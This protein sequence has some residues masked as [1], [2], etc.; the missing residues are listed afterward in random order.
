MITFPLLKL[1]RPKHLL[2]GAVIAGVFAAGW[3]TNG[4]RYKS[5]LAAKEAA[6]I[7]AYEKQRSQYLRRLKTQQE[8]DQAAAEA[9]SAD[10]RR[11]RQ[12]HRELEERLKDAAVVKPDAELCKNGANPFGTDFARLW[13]AADTP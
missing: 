12:S 7:A 5:K 3:T 2:I 13:N 10:L 6:I 4:W 11:V 8:S 1:I 9:L